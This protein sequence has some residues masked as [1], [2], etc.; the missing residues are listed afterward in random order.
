MILYKSLFI[1]IVLISCMMCQFYETEN[2]IPIIGIMTKL[3]ILPE[4]NITT[5]KTQFIDAPYVRYLEVG[6]AK[7][8]YVNI[9][10]TEENLT[11]LFCKLNG[12]LIPGGAAAFV[13]NNTAT[14]FTK[15]GKLF[16]DLAMKAYDK[17]D[18]FPIWGICLG[19]ELIN[20]IISDS[21]GILSSNCDCKNYNQI[22]E[23]TQNAETSKL[24]NRFTSEELSLLGTNQI[25]YNNHNLF[26]SV[27]DFMKYENLTNLFNILAVSGDKKNEHKFI[28]AIEGKKYPIYGVQ[29]HP[30]KSAYLFSPGFPILHDK[31]SIS[32]HGSFSRFF[33][34]EAKK[35]KHKFENLEE[36]AKHLV[37]SGEIGIESELGPVYLFS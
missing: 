31:T 12:L 25:S 3:I 19:F 21:F 17:G 7:V 36:E 22:L 34:E 20:F 8:A 37:Y 23:F 9:D 5:N 33:V 28:A 29:F 30:E 27:K 26:V 10:D 15:T 11:K 32:L 6:G 16:I 18:Y 35:S 4:Y 2:K 1:L 24:F 14:N 13:I